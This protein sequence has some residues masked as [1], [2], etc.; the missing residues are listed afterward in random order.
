L[1]IIDC[2]LGWNVH[3][4]TAPTVKKRTIIRPVNRSLAFRIGD[5][6][7]EISTWQIFDA[8]SIA[9]WLNPTA[10]R[11]LERRPSCHRRCDENFA[12][13][14]ADAANFD[15]AICEHFRCQSR[16]RTRQGLKLVGRRLHATRPAA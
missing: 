1:I 7:S 4:L 13:I 16:S 14:G 10:T 12:A 2:D 15:L 6:A 8:L 5:A 9:A 11:D 3:R